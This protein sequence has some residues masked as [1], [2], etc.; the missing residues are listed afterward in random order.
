MLA[1]LKINDE[2][3]AEVQNFFSDLAV[4]VLCIIKIFPL[5]KYHTEFEI[6]TSN[7]LM[8]DIEEVEDERAVFGD[9]HL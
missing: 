1:H 4:C 8:V 5:Y 3:Y 6:T 2:C 7:C 9:Q